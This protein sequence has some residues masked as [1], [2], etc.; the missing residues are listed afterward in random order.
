MYKWTIL[1]LVCNLSTS[2]QV[3]SAQIVATEYVNLSAA[4]PS[5][6]GLAI[7]AGHRIPA[8]LGTP[9]Q[10][11]SLHS[12]SRGVLTPLTFQIDQK[13][14]QGRYQ[15]QAGPTDRQQANTKVLDE[16][17]E[18][19]FRLRDSGKKLP[20]ASEFLSLNALIE[21]QVVDA[22]SGI[23]GWI[24]ASTGK[25]HRPPP[26]DSFI[27]Y[28]PDT[29]TVRS[30]L[31]RIGFSQQLPFLIDRFHWSLGQDRGWSPNMGDTMKIRHRGLFLGFLPFERTQDDYS[32]RLEAVKDGPLRVI[33]R[34]SNRIR[35]LWTLK[36]PQLYVDYVMM[37][38]GFIMDT[39]IDVP[40]D[41][42]LF[43]DSVETLTTMDWND[44]VQLPR[45]TVHGPDGVTSLAV[46]GLMSAD[47]LTFNTLN[48]RQFALSSSYGRLFVRLD[49]ADDFPIRPWLY[50]RDDSEQADPPE[51]RGGQFGN[52]GFRTTEW[53]R[54]GRGVHHLSFRVCMNSS[55]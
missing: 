34:T 18:L 35:V 13:D 41:I 47:E 32:S 24:Y 17:D 14:S 54:V 43:F 44:D 51:N 12:Y 6:Q 10:R 49:L 20:S 53:E 37:P 42:G 39:I 31:Y 46:D 50:L 26:S 55:S 4:C 2:L 5:M 27:H 3:S 16:N 25:W 38:D 22:Q 21:I 33:R 29:D 28:L 48:A 45:M 30:G 15:I 11:I 52:V 40:F 8:L 9:L 23:S 7:V 19:V 1:I 36:T